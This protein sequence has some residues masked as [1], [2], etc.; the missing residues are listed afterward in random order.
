LEKLIQTEAAKRE[1]LEKKELAVV[2]EQIKQKVANNLLAVLKK[3]YLKNY[4]ET[5]FDPI[6][7]N[8]SVPQEIKSQIQQNSTNK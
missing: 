5:V 1:D 4:Q 2:L 8:K 7:A 3:D 6:L